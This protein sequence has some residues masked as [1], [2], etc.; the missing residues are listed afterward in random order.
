[1][2]KP[3]MIIFDAGR[4]LLDYASIDTQKGVKALL[5]YITENPLNLSIAEIDQRMDEIAASFDACK[6]QLFEVPEQTILTLTFNLLQLKFSIDVS[7]IERILWNTV[8]EIVPTPHAREI[9]DLLNE[10]GIQTAVISNLDFSGSLLAERLNKLYPNNQFRFVIASSDYGIRKPNPFI[11]EAGIAKSGFD[12]S[13]IWYVGDKIPV[14]VKG[15]SSVG[16][17][18][19]LFKCP[20]NH[21]DPIPEGLKTMDDF[22]DLITLVNAEN[23]Y[24]T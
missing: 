24:A 13:D 3:K 21:Y 15:S 20:R 19:V 10:M 11:F 1:M 12:A 17:T 7:E 5:P 23:G 22:L 16:M 8:P 9:L 2:S 4:T 14:D 18:P 6:K